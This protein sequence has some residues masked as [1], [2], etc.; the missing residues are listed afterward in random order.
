MHRRSTLVTKLFIDVPANAKPGTAELAV[1][2]IGGVN[3]G[4]LFVAKD[5]QNHPVQSL[6][7]AQSRKSTLK[8]TVTG[9]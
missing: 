3:T 6:I 8:T 5:Y 9:R 1:T 4:R 2:A 7:V